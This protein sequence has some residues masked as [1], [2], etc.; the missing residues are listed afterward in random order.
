MKS[1]SDFKKSLSR[2]KDSLGF[3]LIEI[4][5]TLVFIT[6]VISI[7]FLIIKPVQYLKVSRDT[8]RIEMLDSLSSAI[9]Q[10]MSGDPKPQFV[11]GFN[12][13][14]PKA[15]SNPPFIPLDQISNCKATINCCTVDDLKHSGW[16]S[17]IDPTDPLACPSGP[18]FPAWAIDL[19][20][21]LKVMPLDPINNDVFHFRYQSNDDGDKFSL[22]A[23]YESTSF[24]GKCYQVGT[25]TPKNSCWG[26]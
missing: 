4:V 18:N 5:I 6:F 23:K 10:Y 24:N 14:L 11:P 25:F 17:P 19:S 8:Q 15:P 3:T 22:T 16:L 12:P 9:E 20:P 2:D 21:F 26:I 13:D 1:F 7:L